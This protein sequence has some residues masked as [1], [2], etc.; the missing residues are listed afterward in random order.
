MKYLAIDIGGTFIKYAIINAKYEIEKNWKVPSRHSEDIS[1]W[2]H[3][4]GQISTDV[5]FDGIGISV[6][7]IVDDS[8]IVQSKSS[9][10]LKELYQK[11]I[12]RIFV[13]KYH[14]PVSVINDGKAAGL[15]ECKFGY[16]KIYKYC[17][18][19][20]IGT[21]IGGCLCYN[22][23]VLSG[24]DNAAGEFHLIPNYDLKESK[25]FNIGDRC[26]VKTLERKY[27]AITGRYISS[28][29]IFLL[30]KKSDHIAQIV[31]DEWITDLTVLLLTVTSIYNPD[32][33]CIGGAISANKDFMNTL[34]RAYKK[35][36]EI[37]F[38]NFPAVA[39]QIT[40]CS[41]A[42]N[43]N[44]LGAIIHLTSILTCSLTVN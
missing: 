20:V 16:A 18:C 6:P 9:S 3:L 25:I 23:K 13:E 15:Y 29:E 8:G 7:G 14:I 12:C 39:A 17:I 41:K 31:V 10:V 5:A 32:V 1:L 21:G 19:L 37:Y 33:I 44:L 30:Y 34:S 26:K 36:A 27:F 40:C 43:N 22:G 11:N 24:K 38:K 42:G 4:F 35:Q 2:D 28:H